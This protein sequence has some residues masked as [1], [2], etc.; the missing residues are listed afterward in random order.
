MDCLR[1]PSPPRWLQPGLPLPL[2]WWAAV[3]GWALASSAAALRSASA[4]RRSWCTPAS[5]RLLQLHVQ[6][7]RLRPDGGQR[8]PY[9]MRGPTRLRVV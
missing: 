6:T 1:K 5:P 7:L 3:T 8:P 4:M 9:A 2:L